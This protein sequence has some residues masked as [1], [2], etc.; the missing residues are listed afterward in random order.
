MN[1]EEYGVGY[2]VDDPL[3]ESASQYTDYPSDREE[4]LSYNYRE[5]IHEVLDSVS[6]SMD[7]AA[8]EMNVD[9]STVSAFCREHGRDYSSD[10]LVTLNG[11]TVETY[12][13]RVGTVDVDLAPKTYNILEFDGG[14]PL[15]D[16]EFLKAAH[17]R[18]YD[19]KDIAGLFDD[20][21]PREA[22][23]ALI[24]EGLVDRDYVEI[25]GERYELDDYHDR[26][27]CDGRLLAAFDRANW[28]IDEVAH[29]L[30]VNSED[31]AEQVRLHG[32]T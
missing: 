2:H 29:T 11:A 4:A 15:K 12:K 5:V 7:L 30:G 14:T 23:D 17:E 18:H 8:E 16:S 6:G 32:L 3:A 24:A 21:D 25:D 19:P 9:K 28:S 10:L 22:K 26:P 1:P 13:A 31:V 27:Y 20:V